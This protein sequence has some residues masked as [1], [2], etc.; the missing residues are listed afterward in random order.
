MPRKQG[1][2]K[3]SADKILAAFYA[4]NRNRQKA[5]D[6][7]KIH[8]R[9]ICRVLKSHHGLISRINP[10]FAAL[11]RADLAAYYQKGLTIQQLATYFRMQ[12]CHVQKELKKAGIELRK[13]PHLGPKKRLVN[14]RKPILT[15]EEIW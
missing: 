7:L 1:Q 5:A 2:L 4:S 9:T 3:V 10:R 8:Y 14:R 6:S 12:K 11:R 13:R 15:A